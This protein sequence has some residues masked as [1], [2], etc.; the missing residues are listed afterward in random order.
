MTS[1]KFPESPTFLFRNCHN[2]PR[3]QVIVCAD[4][5]Q[6]NP[7]MPCLN[8]RI[9]F[10]A[11]VTLS[12]FYAPAQGV[13]GA[14]DREY[15]PVKSDLGIFWI[16]SFSHR[17]ANAAAKPRGPN[18]GRPH[19]G[20]AAAATNADAAGANCGWRDARAGRHDPR[21][22]A[23]RATEQGR[24]GLSAE[25]GRPRSVRLVAPVHYH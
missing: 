5:P 11:S 18:Q 2:P 10:N 3:S 6:V 23:G 24:V 14:V 7:A 8:A 1:K 17:L 22:P 9:R 16:L 12:D 25:L 13:L 4:G 21:P 20:T 15:W 19:G